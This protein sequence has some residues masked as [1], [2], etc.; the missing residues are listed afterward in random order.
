MDKI[1]DGLIASTFQKVKDVDIFAL[2]AYMESTEGLET[3]LQVTLTVI[4]W[5]TE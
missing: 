4:C 1:D 3:G 2:K 5:L